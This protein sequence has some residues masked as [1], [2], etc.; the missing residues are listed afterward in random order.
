MVYCECCGEEDLKSY[1][2]DNFGSIFCND[3]CL[4]NSLEYR[5]IKKENI[6]IVK[7]VE[8]VEVTKNV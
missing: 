8:V 2:I 1:I 5:D 4:T 3:N 6:R 7:E